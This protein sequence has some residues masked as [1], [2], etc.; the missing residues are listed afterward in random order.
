MTPAITLRGKA[1]PENYDFVYIDDTAQAFRLIGENGKPFCKYV[2]GSSTAHPLREFLLEMQ[3]A[4]APRLKFIFGDVP[5]TG[6]PLLIEYYD[7]A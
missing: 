1:P 5:F 3:E 2:I 6:I 7:T 4:I